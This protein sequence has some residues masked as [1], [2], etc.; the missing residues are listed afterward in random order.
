MFYF[1]QDGC[2][3]PDI[4]KCIDYTLSILEANNCFIA[5]GNC[6]INVYCITLLGGLLGGVNPDFRRGDYNDRS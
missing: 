3:L 6:Y 5:P 1:L 2:K 4:V